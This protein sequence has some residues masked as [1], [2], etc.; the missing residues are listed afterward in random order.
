MAKFVELISPHKRQAIAREVRA[1][2]EHTIHIR[3]YRVTLRL[4]GP[5]KEHAGRCYWDLF[6]PRAKKLAFSGWDQTIG[7]AL[8]TVQ[9]AILADIEESRE[10]R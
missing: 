10:G 5:C 1:K 7:G 6:A 4:E 3:K 9:A 8:E 2:R